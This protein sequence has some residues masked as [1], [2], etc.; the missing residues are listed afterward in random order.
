MSSK[1]DEYRESAREC[2]RLA[3]ITTDPHLRKI[4][5]QHA[6]EWLRLAYADQED[7]FQHV[8]AGFN[9]QSLQRQPVQQQQAKLGPDETDD[10]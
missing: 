10:S 5:R 4:L 9:A 6:Q 8:I 1:R 2:I 7:V 3:A